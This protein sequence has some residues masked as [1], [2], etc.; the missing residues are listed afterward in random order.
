MKSLLILIATAAFIAAP[1]VTPPFTGYDPGLF[2]VRIERPSIQPAGYAFSIWG[3]IYLWLLV[4]AVAGLW[5]RNE[6]TW[7][8]PFLPHLAAL[9]LGTIWLAI[10][11]LYPILATVTITVMAA[12]TWAAFL[13]ADDG[14]D[15]WLQQA[16]LGLFAGWLTAAAAVSNGILLG[17]YGWLSDTATALVMLAVALIIALVIQSRR[18]RMPSYFA[19]VIW[20][21][22]GVAVVN[23]QANPVA[24]WAALAGAA[25]LAVMASALFLRR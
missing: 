24:A 12:C 1:T 7:A 2:P 15:R 21:S 8:R 4:S 10:A 6:A 18:P 3:L 16:P 17:G 5:R 25:L 13:R 20:A 19:A 23:W 14:A 22:I 11:P 9:L